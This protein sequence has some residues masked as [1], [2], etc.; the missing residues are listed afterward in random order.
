M[1]GRRLV[2]MTMSMVES[3]YNA[4]AEM[5][6]NS[7]R[8]DITKVYD[9][10]VEDRSDEA[11]A[12]VI[13]ATSAARNMYESGYFSEKEGSMLKKQC[14]ETLEMLKIRYLLDSLTTDEMMEC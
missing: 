14:A 8:T 2:C 12:N 7:V 6:Y 9:I 10:F 3:G 5:R 1:C 11:F 13:K 4:A